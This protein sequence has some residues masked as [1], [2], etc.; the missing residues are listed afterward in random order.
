M[1]VYW[2]AEAQRHALPTSASEGGEEKMKGR[3]RLEWGRWRRRREGN[4]CDEYN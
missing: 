1:K 3:K 4:Y 2:G